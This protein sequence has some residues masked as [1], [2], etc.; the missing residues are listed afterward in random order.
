MFTKKINQCL[1]LYK[2][3]KPESRINDF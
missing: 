2:N 1:A 3:S